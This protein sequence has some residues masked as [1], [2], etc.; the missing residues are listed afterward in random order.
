MG[1]P[2]SVASQVAAEAVRIKISGGKS[3]MVQ[4]NSLR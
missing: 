2:C 3:V 1:A 4:R